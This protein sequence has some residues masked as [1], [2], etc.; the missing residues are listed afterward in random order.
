MLPAAPGPSMIA[1]SLMRDECRRIFVTN[2]RDGAV[3]MH[4]IDGDPFF[5]SFRFFGRGYNSITT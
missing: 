1:D 3:D 5:L 4:V 2:F